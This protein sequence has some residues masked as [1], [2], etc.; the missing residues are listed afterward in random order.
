[1]I[2]SEATT[3]DGDF[4]PGDSGGTR[5]TAAIEAEHR[6]VGTNYRHAAGANKWPCV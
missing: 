2:F 3:S 5:E 4:E 1:M 6:R